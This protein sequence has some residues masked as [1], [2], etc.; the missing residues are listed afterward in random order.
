[1]NK[2]SIG[3]LTHDSPNRDVFL[4]WTI[5]TFMLNTNVAKGTKWY[6]YHNGP[7]GGKNDVVFYEMKEK[8]GH[9]I[10][11]ELYHTGKNMGVGYG[12]NSVNTHLKNYKYSLFLEGDWITL[13]ETISGFN[14]EWLNDCIQLLDE[15]ESVDQIQLRRY[16]HDIDDRQYG[17]G[18]WIRKENIKKETE[19]FL[20]IH[21]REYGNNPTVR[22]NQKHYDIGIFP[23]GEFIDDNN[24]PQELKGNPLWGQAEIAASGLGH[25]LGTVTLKFGNFVHC[26]HW[27]QYGDNFELAISNITGCGYKTPSQ[28]INCKYGFLFPRKQFCLACRKSFDF[29]DLEEH[30]KFFEEQIHRVIWEKQPKEKIKE[31]VLKNIDLPP[32]DIDVYIDASIKEP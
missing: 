27:Q 23:L 25:K 4:K 6:I 12:I 29:T 19:K 10:D 32:V 9:I 8:W 22:R 26:D 31:V 14:K 7:A 11:F 13:P 30:N 15:D 28:T 16:L 2:F 24:E 18:Y 17:Y 20:Y 3:T 1:M 21:K 5:D